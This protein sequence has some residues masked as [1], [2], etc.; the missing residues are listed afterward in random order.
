MSSAYGA[1]QS[2]L[3]I[4]NGGRSRIEGDSYHIRL[5]I[6]IILRAYKT[7][8]LDN[9]FDFAVAME[10][11]AAGKFDD[12]L[13]HYSS[14]RMGTGYL[15][16]QA[17]HKKNT[18]SKIEKDGLCSAWD[19]NSL[20][21]IPKYF[22]SYLEIDQKLPNDT[23]YVLCN[24][25]GL[26][27]QV[28]GYFK[29]IIPQLDNYLNFCIDIR[30][31]CFQFDW[32]KPFPSLIAALQDSCLDKL[33][34]EFAQNIFKDNVITFNDTLFNIF[35]NLIYDSI[36]PL[37]QESSDSV[38]SYKLTEAFLYDKTKTIE[39]VRTAFKKE[40]EMLCKRKPQTSNNKKM[41]E[42][43]IKIDQD[44]FIAARNTQDNQK[45]NEK[46]REFYGKFLLVCNSFNQETLREKAIILLSQ[47]CNAEQGTVFEK[48]QG[49][50]L[51]AMKTEQR[52]P[53]DFRFWQ[54]YF[55]C[56]D[57]T[58]KF[59]DLKRSSK[60]Y[61]ETV[62][63]NNPHI[64]VHP[65]H[66]KVS[67]L[68]EFLKDESAWGI[69]EFNST[70]DLT[71]SSRIVVQGLSLLKH[72]TIFVD[73]IK[74]A[75]QHAMMNILNDLLTYLRDVNHPTIKVITIL[76]K[77][78]CE[79]VDEIKELSKKY[80]QKIV[81][82]QQLSGSSQNDKVFE[83]IQVK[84]LSDE[85]IKQ[86]YTQKELKMFGT[87]TP[88]SS[89]VEE[90]DD[91]NLLLNV[92]ELCD[93]PKEIQNYK[94]NV[95]NYENIKNWYVQRHF[96]SGEQ[97]GTEEKGFYQDNL[98]NLHVEKILV[99]DE[100]ESEAPDL[101]DSHGG[102]VCIFL[103]DAGLGKTTY[104]TWLA[105]HLSTFEPSRYVIKFIAKEFSTDFKRLLGRNIQN[106]EDTHIVRI[107]YC[108]IHLALFVPSINKRTINET[109][110][111]RSEA[112]RCAEL[113][114]CLNGQILL[115]KT[116]I[117]ELSTKEF[118]ELRFFQEKFNSRKIVLILDGFDEIAPYYNDV[119]KKC[120]ARFSSLD[121]IR[122]LYLSS[123]PYGFEEELKESFDQCRF[124]R[125]K[126][127]SG[128]DIIRSF[129]K[130][131][132]IKL[133]GYK[134]Y[135]R[136]H[137]CEIL[138]KLYEVIFLALNDLITVPLLLH[139]VQIIILPEI[140]RRVSKNHHT[141]TRDI[142]DKRK[143]M[144]IDK[145]LLVEQFIERK[146][147]ILHVDKTGMTDA[148]ATTAAAQIIGERLKKELKEQHM[149]LAMCVIFDSN[150]REKLL[151]KKEQK[152]ADEIMEEVN[153]G[154]E[155]MGIVLGVQ[156]GVPQFL[157]RS[158][159]EYFSACWLY[160]NW[161]WLKRDKLFRSQTIWTD[162]LKETREFFD[163]LILSESEGCDL[164]LALVNDSDEQIDKILLNNPSAL[165]AR[166]K[167]G[168]LPLHLSEYIEDNIDNILE[169]TPPELINEKD[170][171]CGWNAIDYSFVLCQNYLID[172]L[173]RRGVQPNM[174]NLFEQVCSNDL[175]VL[176][177]KVNKYV[178]IFDDRLK[179]TDLAEELSE[180]VAK[181]LIAEKQLDI[182]SPLTELNSL[183]VLEK[184]VTMN[185]LPMFRQLVIKSGPET[186]ALDNRVNRLLQLSLQERSYD[187]KNYLV[188]HHPSIVPMINDHEELF[189]CS[190]RA[191]EENQMELF[192]AIFNQFC[193]NQNIECV[194]EATI[195]NEFAN[196]DEN[197]A[198]EI[199]IPFEKHCC[200]K[201]T[202]FWCF[203][204][205][206]SYEIEGILSLAIHYGNTQ[207]VSYIL[208]KTKM[209]VTVELIET[210]M[211]QLG[212]YYSK[213]NNHKKCM[214]AFKYLFR[215]IDDLYAV[216]EEGHTLFLMIIKFGCVYMLPSLIAIGF[217]PESINVMDNWD[218]FQQLFNYWQQKMS[219]NMCVYLQQRSIVDCFDTVGPTGESIFDLANT[220]D[221]FIVSQALV[222]D[223]FRNLSSR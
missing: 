51:E 205:R 104:F 187:I 4:S 142:L 71:V 194:E 147:Q 211:L 63:E 65:E 188:E 30:A 216:N 79:S 206:K 169:K 81:V 189:S 185:N 203:G 8:Q 36:E 109:D 6:M 144:Q 120:F 49:E 151:S 204:Q 53:L 108:Y 32:D 64:E 153:E 69:Y 24:N 131:L 11:A 199:E 83:K 59:N 155:K 27:K 85:A 100:T 126:P 103:N 143:A 33:G 43:I 152:R 182:Y 1:V 113:L 196:H 130:Y 55:L 68:Y 44:S 181:Y 118:I 58:Q 127:F 135:E 125:L 67:K 200:Y 201:P 107:L 112:E 96:V 222:E 159:A 7:R 74:Y 162:S 140:K 75:T 191:I 137:C 60:E 213:N 110:V 101:E 45:F 78:N 52:V 183:A 37:E 77:Y 13:Y 219:A 212:I 136:K 174:D 171:L 208:Q 41:N 62:H 42:L 168:R 28:E 129:H 158:F 40:W 10:V 202:K 102:K 197:D 16:I 141:I 215:K 88:L 180:R 92:L 61:L 166:D 115:D 46:V 48:L 164:H 18:E 179:Q 57:R 172:V 21:S 47:W 177:V 94:L 106:L 82:A 207:M 124:Y 12:I 99:S 123:R 9:K 139:M 149:L 98:W 220:T 14:P 193:I 50:L 34:K 26:H 217:V 2:I 17:K 175:A 72:E 23:R 80:C 150:D 3:D 178:K 160:E 214:P 97:E 138:G 145:L 22:V 173:F 76:G 133:D 146:L 93:Q 114:K 156:N 209:V 19:G 70:L 66:L 15:F 39:K 195:I 134:K 5:A 221:N 121:G 35:A 29:E 218:V 165:T 167:V 198:F 20:C 154:E 25:I 84:D 105:W 184:V 186:L 73:S 157:H 176:L 54:N 128:I 38:C 119:V 148:A 161:D 190:A 31:K 117:N 192:K 170:E 95:Q 132:L 91:L 87:T 122:S 56:I 90:T 86:L 89:I 223:K 163:R 116:K 210:I 111:V